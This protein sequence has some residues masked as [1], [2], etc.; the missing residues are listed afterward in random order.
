MLC[1]DGPVGFRSR[2]PRSDSLGQDSH[3]HGRLLGRGSVGR[4]VVA[5]GMAQ[6]PD[7]MDGLSAQLASFCIC[8]IA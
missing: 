7:S 1:G 3:S 4:R 6:C 8:K 5:G 2:A